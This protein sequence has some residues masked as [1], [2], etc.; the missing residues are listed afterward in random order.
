MASG[1]SIVVDYVQAQNSQIA[2]I[3]KSDSGHLS[4]ILRHLT[5]VD[6][7]FVEILLHP[8][9]EKKREREK[10]SVASLSL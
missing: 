4:A 9:V 10:V 2:R 7:L 1:R 3:T 8:S 6:F 5:S